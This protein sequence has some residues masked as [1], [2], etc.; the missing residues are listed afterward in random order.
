MVRIGLV[1]APAGTDIT[2][3]LETNIS[4]IKEALS[5]GAQVVCLQELFCFP[6]FPQYHGVQANRYAQTIPG[7]I[8]DTISRLARE[9]GAVIIVPLL[10][11][12][13][14]GILY[15]SA[16]IVRT[17]GNLGQVY[18]KIHI[19]NDPLYY[20]KE[21]FSPGYRYVVEETPFGRIAVLICYDQWFS[22][23]ARLVTLKGADIIFYPTALGTIRGME[24]PLE[25]DWRVAW[26]SIQ[27]GHAI[28]NGV[29]V[30]AVNRVGREGDLC[31]F[32]GS[33]ICDS[34]GNVVARAG[35][36]QEVLLA[37]VD[38]SMNTRIREGWGFLAN[39]RPDT[40]NGLVRQKGTHPRITPAE[41]GFRMPAE[42]EPH[43]GVWLSWPVDNGTFSDLKAVE[44][45][46]VHMIRAL[47]G[48]ERVYLLVQDS[49]MESRVRDLLAREGV[50]GGYV[51]FLVYPYADVWFR[52]YGPTFLVHGGDPSLAMVNW[53]FNA[54]GGKYPEL[55]PDNRIPEFIEKELMI[56]SFVPGMVLE[57]GSIETDGRG[58]L[59]V[60]EQ[61]LLHKNRNPALSKGEIEEKLR[62]YLGVSRVIWL[63]G[64]IAGDDTDGHIDDVAR[65]TSPGTVVC[66]VEDDPHSEN[67][68][69]L[70]ENLALLKGATA[71]DGRPLS[72][73]PL[74]MPETGKEV[75]PASYTNFYIGNGVVLVP[76]FNDPADKTALR[77]L[78]S[79]FPGRVVVGIDCSAMITGMG[80]IHCVTQ[81]FPS[82]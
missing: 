15:N 66:A 71:H 13:E 61:C 63:R 74:P 37:D 17:D 4:L 54:W 62:A 75:L 80:A 70:Q 38:L 44:K 43:Q 7:P 79:L 67:W 30:A 36:G 81:Q 11:A 24:D 39:R 3:N 6:Y 59:L 35:T 40:Y 42:W 56:P 25:G 5:R 68:S 10:E 21:Y 57:G 77:I 69:I 60:T 16:V 14:G 76:T 46:Y 78:E 20:E 18:R 8:T 34:F 22:E 53:T 27:R 23:A 29:H 32:G 82:L 50:P 41:A 28:G 9:H 73:V 45:A 49:G 48:R 65:F 31:F 19:P 2:A 12:G 55:V 51:R 33:F 1:Q 72:I 26:E 47:L 64:G 52:D 58:T